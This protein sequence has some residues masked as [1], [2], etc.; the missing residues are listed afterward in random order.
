MPVMFK[1]HA[2]FVREHLD[3][4]DGMVNPDDHAQATF[5]RFDSSNY[6]ELKKDNHSIIILCINNE[7]HEIDRAEVQP[8]RFQMRR[9]IY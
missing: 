6:A 3:A 5:L 1:K 4:I 8:I 7:I 9:Y 2:D